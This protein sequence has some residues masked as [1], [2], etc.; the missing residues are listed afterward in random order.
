MINFVLQE[1]L[2][3]S[4]ISTLVAHLSLKYENQWHNNEF[5]RAKVSQG[6]MMTKNSIVDF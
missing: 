2:F 3:I 5:V 6:Y 4:A 1:I